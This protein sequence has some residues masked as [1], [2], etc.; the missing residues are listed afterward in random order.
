MYNQKIE[1]ISICSRHSV[2]IFVDPSCFFWCIHNQVV[3]SHKKKKS[4]NKFSRQ[5]ACMKLIY[6]YKKKAC[7]KCDWNHKFSSY[8]YTSLPTLKEFFKIPKLPLIWN[9][10]SRL[11]IWN[12]IYHSKL[13]LLLPTP[14]KITTCTQ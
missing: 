10:T 2:I 7:M 6:I 5:K 4:S 13:R 12:I 3:H 1:S 14:N 9:N 11:L 8:T